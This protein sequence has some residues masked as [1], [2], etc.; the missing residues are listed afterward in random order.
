MPEA[1]AAFFFPIGMLL[2]LSL[3]FFQLLN[4]ES[5]NVEDVGISRETNLVG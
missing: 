3:T 1:L 5:L 4:P 2:K